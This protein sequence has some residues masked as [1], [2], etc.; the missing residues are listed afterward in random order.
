MADLELFCRALLISVFTVSLLGKLRDPAGFAHYLTMTRVVP[1][2]LRAATAAVV[3]ATEAAVLI[4]LVRGGVW[5]AIGYPAALVLLTTFSI[6]VVTM[7]RTRGDVVCHCFGPGRAPVSARHLMRNGVLLVTAGCG[8]A[9]LATERTS[10]ATD[11]VLVIVLAALVCGLLVLLPELGPAT[12]PVLPNGGRA[13]AFEERTLGGGTFTSSGHGKAPLVLVFLSPGCEECRR[14]VPRLVGLRDVAARVGVTVVPV[15]FE[16]RY[17]SRAD[18]E[19][20]AQDSALVEPVLVVTTD[21]PLAK[22]YNPR[23][24]TPFYYAIDNG[25]IRSS[26]VVGTRG[27]TSDL[28][29]LLAESSPPREDSPRRTAP[30]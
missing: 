8:F 15:F 13:P 14:H 16:D 20:Y 18:I 30:S 23:R 6:V 2:S 21:S 1:R 28:R 24:Q 9:L 19:Q 25:H 7:L 17:D 12:L 22:K 4:A 10:T 26:G 29:S 27:W 11:P 3:G 5:A